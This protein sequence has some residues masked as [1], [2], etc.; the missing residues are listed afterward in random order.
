MT[1]LPGTIPPAKERSRAPGR[2]NVLHPFDRADEVLEKRGAPPR[3]SAVIWPFLVGLALA[4]VAPKLMSMLESLD[5][6]AE[7]AV[8]P[9]VLL[10]R[11]PEFGLN[12]K[13]GGYLPRVILFAQFPL[14]GLLTTINLRRRFP[15][16]V[17]IG[18]LIVIH[19]VGAF[20][21]FAILAPHGR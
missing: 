19:L 8:F 14:E 6:W 2:G 7:R 18:L 5:P 17:A 21:L 13:L 1:E 11:L 9:Y 10:A 3:Y 16:W 4:V 12:W 15:T 20:V